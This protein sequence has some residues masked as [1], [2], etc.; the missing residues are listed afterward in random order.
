M[1][2]FA[3]RVYVCSAAFPNKIKTH[4][5]FL[6][7]CV[8]WKAEAIKKVKTWIRPSVPLTLFIYLFIFVVHVSGNALHGAGQPVW[9]E[10]LRVLTSFAML[11]ALAAVVPSTAAACMS[12]QI[13][14]LTVVIVKRGEG[15]TWLFSRSNFHL[16]HS[17]LRLVYGGFQNWVI[18]ET[19]HYRD[20][21]LLQSPPH[22]S[23]P[24]V[25]RFA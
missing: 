15:T 14:V 20:F 24:A 18:E 7:F 21:T 5:G 9:P 4:C 22:P 12:Q 17:K 25:C 8:R 1:L 6:F 10:A 16:L 23:D 3:W 19:L 11:V 2:V 13:I